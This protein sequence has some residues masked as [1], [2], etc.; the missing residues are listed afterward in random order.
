M[1]CQHQSGFLAKDSTVSQLA[2]LVHRWHMALE[3][4]KTVQAAFLDLSKAYD[5]VCL[6]G[7]MFK[8]SN[9]GFAPGSLRWFSLFLLQRT[10]CV[11][12][13]SIMSSW[14]TPRSGIPQG[15]VLGPT[16]FLIFINDLP[17]HLEADCSIFADD[18]TVFA[19]GT[20]PYTTCAGLS[21]DLSSAS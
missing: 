19:S 6:S 5:R 15:T 18:T 8:L 21:E 7:L 16:P 3:Q 10:Q 9:I 17:K 14:Q 1:I 20:D 13:N 11:K 2:F 12:V 4:R